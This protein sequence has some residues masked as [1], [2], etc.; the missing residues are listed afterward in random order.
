M[1]ANAPNAQRSAGT[2]IR[3]TRAPPTAAEKAERVKVREEEA[4]LAWKE[5]RR[6]QQAVDEN[7]ARLKALRLAREHNG[8]E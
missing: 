3:E 5:Y 7:T 6:K 2:L 4:R 8:M 1:R